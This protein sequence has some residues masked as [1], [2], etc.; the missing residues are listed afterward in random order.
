MC[1]HALIKTPFSQFPLTG[2]ASTDLEVKSRCG[3]SPTRRDRG[4]HSPDLLGDAKR[5]GHGGKS[6]GVVHLRDGGKICFGASIAPSFAATSPVRQERPVQQTTK[7]EEF[8]SLLLFFFINSK[9][10]KYS[11]FLFSPFLLICNIN[12]DYL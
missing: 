3:H 6:Y 4:Q 9:Q 5:D 7:H 12:V 1:A 11:Y 10:F 8:L 2:T